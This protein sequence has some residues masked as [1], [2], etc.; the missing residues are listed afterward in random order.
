MFRCT[1]CNAEYE[2]KPDYCDC[3]NNIFEKVP[4][5]KSAYNI[6]KISSGQ[7]ISIIIFIFCLI[8]AAIP[9]TI[10]SNTQSKTEKELTTQKLEKPV[11]NIP[12]ID[13]I[14][15]DNLKQQAQIE[16]AN[17]TNKIKQTY[18]QQQIKQVPKKQEKII[19]QNKSV[20]KTA[21]KTTQNPKNSNKINQT[22]LSQKAQT[23]IN[24]TQ[25][26]DIKPEQKPKTSVVKIQ[27]QPKQQ[28]PVMNPTEFE[29]YKNS[30]R[31]ALLSKLDL[32]KI[33]G[34]GECA[35][36]F[37]LGQNGKLLNRGF[38]YQSNNKTLNDQIYLMLM[39]LPA[40][41]TPPNGYNGEIIKIK[42]YI[43]NGAY[44]ISF[45]D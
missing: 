35:I 27:N 5:I 21:P 44:E 23:K 42:F 33:K 31:L 39:R 11:I 28:K 14:W 15:N 37:S 32:V 24:S 1:D 40:Y 3:G 12:S 41:K 26:N 34:T 25:N 2:I 36:K 16:I 17:S 10:P 20:K 9:W 6:N 18:Q 19:Y 38:I 29:N 30:I 43:D 7:I 8:L 13:E 45:I 4:Q 22:N